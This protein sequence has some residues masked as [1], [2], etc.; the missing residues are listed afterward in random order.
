MKMVHG[1]LNGKADVTFA[2][3]PRLPLI[4]CVS[5]SL[6][7]S[8][9]K[10]FICTKS[11]F[12]SLSSC[13]VDI[14]GTW[15]CLWILWML[16]C[17]EGWISIFPWKFSFFL[18]MALFPST[19]SPSSEYPL[20][21]HLCYNIISAMNSLCSCS[22]SIVPKTMI[23][24]DDW[25][26]LFTSEVFGGSE[27]N[28]VLYKHLLLYNIKKKLSASTKLSKQWCNRL[29]QYHDRKEIIQNFYNTH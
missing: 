22:W 27:S 16:T 19:I 12:N 10:H 9:C 1:R 25:I 4:S 20:Y 18:I 15:D 17:F 28:K 11:C 14:V 23:L 13:N 2:S 21:S 3:F 5:L 6:F 8:V 26:Y 24:I 7:V 29:T